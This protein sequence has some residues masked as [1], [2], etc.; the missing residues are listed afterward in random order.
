MITAIILTKN[1]EERIE[2]CIKSLLWCDE[3]I[4]VDD[5]SIDKTL[6]IAR[7]FKTIVYH[8]HLNNDFAQ[9]RNFGLSKAGNEWVLFV[10]GDEIITKKLREEILSRTEKTNCKGFYLQRRDIFLG[11]EM[12]HGETGNIKLLRLAIRNSGKW[13]RKV[14]EYWNVKGKVLELENRILHEK[15]ENLNEFID[16]LNFYSDIHARELKRERKSSNLLKVIFWPA[17]K[18]I[19]NYF[20]KLGFMDGGAGFIIAVM[21]SFHSYLAWSKLWMD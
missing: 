3:I 15:N 17:G 11:T 2:K 6:R 12:K 18:F 1:E 4:I 16:K 13:Q 14:H 20:L 7:K 9:Q 19:S 5:Y 10:D 8:R 21:M